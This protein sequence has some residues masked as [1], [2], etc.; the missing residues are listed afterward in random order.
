[1]QPALNYIWQQSITF[2]AAGAMRLP[3]TPDKSRP[4]S[5]MIHYLTDY[6]AMKPEFE[7]TPVPFS[8][9]N[10]NAF[11]NFYGEQTQIKR[12]NTVILNNLNTWG[13][14]NLVVHVLYQE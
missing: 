12:K 13:K 5:E 14:L 11:Y 2:V 6:Y 7:L 9:H 1:M 10:D 4:V 3:Q 8:N